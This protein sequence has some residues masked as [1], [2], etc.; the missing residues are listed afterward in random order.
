MKEYKNMNVFKRGGALLVL[1]GSTLLLPAAGNATPIT[2]QYSQTPGTDVFQQ[3]NNSPCVIGDPSCK[4][5]SGMVYTRISGSPA[6]NYTVWSPVYQAAAAYNFGTGQIPLSFFIGVDDNF[7]NT[8]ELLISFETYSCSGPVGTVNL[9]EAT[10]APC[11]GATLVQANSWNPSTPTYSV[12]NMSLSDNGNGYSNFILKG[13]SLNA[14][15]FYAFKA[16]VNADDDGFEEFFIIPAGTP[17]V[18]E[19]LSMGL[20]GTGLIGLFFLRRRADKKA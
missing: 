19:P 9:T 14:G 16:V 11:A 6:E 20:V 4:E 3:T 2:F 7:A 5:P 17:S 18:P 1:V 10:N 12:K 8:A 13:F 15:T